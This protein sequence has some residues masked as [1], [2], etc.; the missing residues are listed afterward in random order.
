MDNHSEIVLSYLGLGDYFNS[1]DSS[2]QVVFYYQKAIDLAKDHNLEYLTTK[3]LDYFIHNGEKLNLIDAE[4]NEYMKTRMQ[5]VE[6]NLKRT[7]NADIKIF[8]ALEKLKSE[9]ALKLLADK[10][11]S[12]F[13]KLNI[14]LIGLILLVGG[15]LIY[16]RQRNLKLKTSELKIKEQYQTIHEQSEILKQVNQQLAKNNSNLKDENDV[17]NLNLIHIENFIKTVEEN[18]DEVKSVL[19]SRLDSSYW[20]EL[21]YIRNF[22]DQTFI[23]EITKK[24]PNL[25]NKEITMCCMIKM[26]L[27]SKEI[28]QITYR[29]LGSVKM[30][31]SRLRKKLKLNAEGNLS[32]FLNR[33]NGVGNK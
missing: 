24:F 10:R 32:S 7:S 21:K 8:E 18:P 22:N 26:G 25:T 12:T 13:K 14:G 31:R 6:D 30:A 11:A 20:D 5:A 33:I 15:L 27:T 4:V 1:T 19:R 2:S 17:N 16:I 28:A 9:E 23:V 29:T 3:A